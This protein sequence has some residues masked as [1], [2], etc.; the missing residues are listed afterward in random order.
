[1]SRLTDKSLREIWVDVETVLNGDPI[2][3]AEMNAVYQFELSGEDGGTYQLLFSEGAAKVLFQAIEEPQCTLKMKI[4][5]FKKFLQGNINSTAAFMMGKLKVEGS[6]GL[7]L[8]LEKLLGQ[9]EL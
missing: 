3:F 8:K 6:I 9:Y 5:D 1:M 7:A 2:P 4:T